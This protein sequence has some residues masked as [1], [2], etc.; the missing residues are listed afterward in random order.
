MYS[1]VFCM[2]VLVC[3]VRICESIQTSNTNGF[4]PHQYSVFVCIGLYWYVYIRILHVS[5]LK[6]KI[7]T[8][9]YVPILIFTV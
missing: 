9:Q 5:S 7:Y 6:Y 4:C 2:Y 3:I 1:Y 8:Y